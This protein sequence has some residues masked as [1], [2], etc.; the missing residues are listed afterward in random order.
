MLVRKFIALCFLMCVPISAQAGGSSEAKGFDRGALI[1]KS[2]ML[3]GLAITYKYLDGPSGWLFRL[4]FY[5]GKTGWT[6]PEGDWTE[7][8]N[9]DNP[10]N[11]RR[12]KEDVYLV[13][14]V[15]T[16]ECA[17][18][19]EGKIHYKLFDFLS[20][21]I[22]LKEKKIYSSSLLYIE[23]DETPMESHFAE[24]EIIKIEKPAK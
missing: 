3:D 13:Q 1:S 21:L 15:E 16:A 8:L 2:N 9:C 17:N 12:I 18:V 4:E 23:E 7:W 24:G 20:L 14:L 6:A 11:A 22:D 10:Y 19:P 5:D